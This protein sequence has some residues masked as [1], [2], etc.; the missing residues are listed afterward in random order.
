VRARRRSAASSSTPCG[1]SSCHAGDR[2]LP[3][4]PRADPGPDGLPHGFVP[5]APAP[6][7]DPQRSR[8][9]RPRADRRALGHRPRRLQLGRFPEP[10]LEWNDRYRITVRRF[11]KGGRYELGPLATALAG[12]SEIFDAQTPWRPEPSTSSPPTTAW[13]WPTSSPIRPSTTTRTART[14]RDGEHDDHS[15]NNGARGSERRSRASAPPRDADIRALL[16]P[17]SPR[18]APS[19]SPPETSSAAASAETT[20][21]MPR[22][23]RSPGSTGRIAT[24][25]LEDLRRGPR[26]PPRPAAAPLQTP[27]RHR[28]GRPARRR[29]DRALRPSDEA[30]GLGG[31]ARRHPRH[32]ARAPPLSGS[33][34]SSTGAPRPVRFHLP[35]RRAIRWPRG[36]SAPGALGPHPRGRTATAAEAREA[37]N[38]RQPAP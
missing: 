17:S 24:V 14:N 12:S 27:L 23:T 11:W 38:T 29:V 22:T 9:R 15:W 10:F 2:R 32:G 25:T 35:E 6:H 18:A 7:R 4:R 34:C 1:T 20:T 13:R 31:R 8:T 30:G 26:R 16:A 5:D 33:P 21:P 28:R 19:C 3:L 37:L 36:T